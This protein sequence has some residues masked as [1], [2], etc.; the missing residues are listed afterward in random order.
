M[1]EESFLAS[2]DNKDASAGE[3]KLEGDQ[4]QAEDKKPEGDKKPAAASGDEWL[5]T[6]P[7]DQREY[8]G[9]KGWK[10]P[11]DALKSY[12]H[13]EE[14]LGAD[15]AGR[16]FLL[17]KDD[18]DKEAYEKI[19]A[20]LGRPEKPEDYGL[21]ELLAGQAY[22]ED[23]SSAA[24]AVMHAAGLSKKQAH[25]VTLAYQEEYRKAAAALEKTWEEGRAFLKAK[26]DPAELEAARRAYRISGATVEQMAWMERQIGPV[27]LTKL[28]ANIGRKLMEDR[29]PGGAEGQ[30]ELISLE[31][32]RNKVDQL[33]ADPNFYKRYMDGEPDANRQIESLYK[34][35][36][37]GEK[38]AAG[39]A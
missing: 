25:L 15:K 27:V 1:S 37:E 28:L 3:A 16:G 26:G 38:R 12:R 33:F 29:Q 39:A 11:D 18:E 32:A 4:K 34:A 35:I 22:S 30:G 17:P 8:V 9:K 5:S 7:E 14:L 10:G 23:F 21:K 19:Y 20:A 13:L 36:A 6:L 31:S 24:A 2:Q